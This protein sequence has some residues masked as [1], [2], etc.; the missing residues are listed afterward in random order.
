[1]VA[2]SLQAVDRGVPL[3]VNAETAARAAAIRDHADA[4]RHAADMERRLA[5]QIENALIASLETVDADAADH[6]AAASV[7]EGL[8]AAADAAADMEADAD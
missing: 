3:L 4:A 6:A 1:M 5:W 7:D 2:H 8:N